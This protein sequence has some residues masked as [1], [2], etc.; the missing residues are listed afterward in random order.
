MF[1]GEGGVIGW[2]QVRKRELPPLREKKK[3]RLQWVQLLCGTSR[4]TAPTAAQ[5]VSPDPGRT[6]ARVNTRSPCGSKLKEY[7]PLLFI[8]QPKV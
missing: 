6:G 3:R 4:A 7:I 2:Q 5:D 1:G 8:T